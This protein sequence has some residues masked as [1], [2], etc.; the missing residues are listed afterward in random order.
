MCEREAKTDSKDDEHG[1]GLTEEGYE[2]AYDDDWA[3]EAC[4]DNHRLEEGAATVLTCHLGVEV[5]SELV[6]YSE[7]HN[8]PEGE[9]TGKEEA[10]KIIDELEAVVLREKENVLDTIPVVEQD[11]RLGWEPRME[12]STDEEHIRWKLRHSDYVLDIEIPTYFPFGEYTFVEAYIFLL[13][14]CL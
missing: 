4:H 11:S 12:Y 2:G 7:L 3:E 14:N 9:A 5:K 1:G 10:G 13:S 6:V 8:Y